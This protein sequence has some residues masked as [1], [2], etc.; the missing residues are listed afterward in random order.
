M[1]PPAL[2]GLTQ[3]I[4]V[5]PSNYIPIKYPSSYSQRIIALFINKYHDARM[6]DGNKLLLL[7]D[8]QCR[9]CRRKIR[10]L[11]RIDPHNRLTF[12]DLRKELPAD[13]PLNLP[14]KELEKQI[15][16]VFPDGTVAAGM[17]AVRAVFRQIGL[18]WLI[19]PTGWP[20]LRFIFDAVYRFIARNRHRFG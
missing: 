19:A 3:T 14:L 8:G 9:F 5:R 18:G 20:G 6:N 17:E 11:R 2:S 4:G 12:C 10:M 16:A 7:Y 15:H 1:Q 13:I